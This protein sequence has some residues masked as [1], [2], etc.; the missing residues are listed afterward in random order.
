ML[1]LIITLAF[2]TLAGMELAYQPPEARQAAIPASF[3]SLW[4][5]I[6]LPG[7]QPPAALS[8][9]P[10]SPSLEGFTPEQRRRADQIISAFENN[11]NILEY[12][13]TEELH[14]GRGLTAGRAGFTTATGDLIVVVQRY[15]ARSPQSPLT[16]YLPRL[17]QVAATMDASLEGLDGL[18][19]DWKQ[20]AKDPTFR[21]V[22]DEV[23]EDLYYRPAVKYWKAL[24]LKTPLGLL[25]LYDTIIQHGD[26]NDPDGLPAL[27]R[28]TIERAGGAPGAD[29]PESEW[30][31]LFLQTRRED[32]AHSFDAD[33]RA[34]WAESVSRC[35]ILS[36]LLRKE[37]YGLRGS[38]TIR[39]YDVWVTIE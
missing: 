35:D 10:A 34:V 31:A 22:Q 4:H 37:N 7:S 17:K 2:A 15:T 21:A 38:L 36:D 8:P 12:G 24:G 1:R 30:L 39:P 29:L 19:E 13:Y 18:A 16:R 28:R 6:F 20:A 26:D 25:I 27:I 33:S 14:D 5:S 9:L 32:L 11:T 23:V 3:A